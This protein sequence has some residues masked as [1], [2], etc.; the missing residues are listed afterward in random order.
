VT[1][2][3]KRILVT[4]VTGQV[5][6]PV[7]KAL[8]KENEVFGL[9]RFG[10]AK[11]RA[12]VEA[13]GVVAVPADLYEGDLEGIPAALD[14]VLHFAV[15]KGG[16]PDFA[17]DIAAN[18]EGAGRLM[19]R[20][21]E[22]EA[23]LHCSS[24]AVY[25]PAGHRALQEEDPLGDNHRNF[26]PTY[27]LSKIATE[28]V[29]RFACRQLDLPTTIARFSVPYGDNGGWPYWH[30]MMMKQGQSIP[31][32]TD[33]P[34]LYNPIHEDD[35]I[36]QIPGLL[37]AATTPATT[38]NWGGS[39]AVSV[40]EWCAYLTELTGIEHELNPQDYHL[41]SLCLDPTRMHALVG[42]T[43]VPWKEGIR[44]MVAARAPDLLK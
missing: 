12:K 32:N 23:F 42:Q 22:A 29:V 16:V 10:R 28:A 15:A 14:Y 27:S 43:T 20:C 8:A 34:N 19:T 4:G 31:V 17:R 18:A 3:G 6:F 38:V 21:C 13:A 9:A 5:G 11:D 7:A 37:A 30:L 33:A 2:A 41:G 36:R 26:M 25:A 1:L 44:R 39:E 40:E 24:A 35:Y